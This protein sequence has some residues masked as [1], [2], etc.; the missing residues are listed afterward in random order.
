MRRTAP[1]LIYSLEKKNVTSITATP[2]G[3]FV[4]LSVAA[5][6]KEEFRTFTERD[7]PI[8]LKKIK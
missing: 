2:T 3:S 1:Q 8:P 5:V 6:W 4:L 7:F